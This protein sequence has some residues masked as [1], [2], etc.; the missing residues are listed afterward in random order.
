MFFKP[1]CLNENTKLRTKEINI[2][3]LQY[4]IIQNQ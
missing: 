1:T 4:N 2:P 3:K